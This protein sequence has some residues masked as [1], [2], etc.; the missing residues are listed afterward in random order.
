MKIE[1]ILEMTYEIPLATIAKKRLSVGE[2][3]V[4]SIL[5][6]IGCVPNGTGK[7]GWTYTGENPAILEKDFSEFVQKAKKQA[8][9]S[10]DD[11][12][13][14]RKEE[15]RQYSQSDIKDDIIENK[16]S[17][18]K[19]EIKGD[20]ELMNVKD[21]IANMIKG[22]E[23][24]KTDKRYKGFYLDADVADAIDQIKTGNKSDTVS[25]IIRI[26]L[27]ENDLL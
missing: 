19:I 1:E 17:D 8:K 4:R 3:K 22:I 15:I 24:E 6:E 10:N 26:Y 13:D 23:P 18:S 2:K 9:P 21:E 25:K 11:S 20:N 27:K 16:A 5:K 14:N 12:L 7:K